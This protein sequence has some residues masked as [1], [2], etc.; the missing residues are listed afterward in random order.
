MELLKKFAQLTKKM[1][2]SEGFQK[3]FNRAKWSILNTLMGLSVS[4]LTFYASQ[5]AEWAIL[6]LPFATAVS[7]LITKE[8][9]NKLK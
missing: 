1:W 5:N 7:Q 4:A 9:T 8:A 6:I 2:Q 3:A